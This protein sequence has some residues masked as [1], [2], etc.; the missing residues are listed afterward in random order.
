MIIEATATDIFYGTLTD[1]PSNVLAPCLIR[2]GVTLDQIRRQDNDAILA[3]AERRKRW[4]DIWSA[5]H[6]V[7]VIHDILPVKS[8][9][10]RLKKEYASAQADLS[11]F[12]AVG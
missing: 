2:A 4:K 6:G 5:G 12:Q 1:A 10:D 3:V 8:L 11:R 7:G 9:S